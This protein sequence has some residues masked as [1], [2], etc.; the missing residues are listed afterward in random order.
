[1]GRSYPPIIVVLGTNASGKSALG[2]ELA[3]QFDG[4]VLSADSRQVYQGFP[5][6]SGK[7]TEAEMQGVAHHGIDLL[8]PDKFYSL[9]DYLQFASA[10]FHD[11]RTRNRPAFLVGG[12]G[13]YISAITEGYILPPVPPDP[14]FREYC[15]TLTSVELHTQLIGLDPSA[16]A[17]IGP[18]NKRRI[19]RALE[20]SR[21]GFTYA[22]SHS[23]KPLPR[24]LKLG[25]KWPP[26]ELRLRI[27]KRLDARIKEGMVDEIVQAR[28][29][30]VS[31]EFLHDLG[32]EYRYILGYLTG[33]FGSKDE[34][35]NA[36]ATAI[37]KFS[38]RQV[39]WFR[40]DESIN[41]LNMEMDFLA[42]A[43]QLVTKFLRSDVDTGFGAL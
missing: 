24:V 10:T 28:Q 30:G 4:E 37:Y 5:L 8:P 29:S 3:K 2:V 6:C 19:I 7:L 14:P 27:R 26:E 18:L 39:A 36:L 42:E 33:Q 32:L 21:A 1:V 40:R 9:E 43:Q 12:T 11:I 17:A 22:T 15:E 20:M 16:A 38:R 41:W 25:V 31:D 35:E 23:R 13:L 34:F